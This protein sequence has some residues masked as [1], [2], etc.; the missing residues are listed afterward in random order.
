LKSCFRTDRYQKLKY[1]MSEPATPLNA[2]EAK[3]H[4]TELVLEH[5][6][7]PQPFRTKYLRELEEDL[8]PIFIQMARDSWTL[9][10]LLV[11]RGTRAG[12]DS[13][14]AYATQRG[15]EDVGRLNYALEEI[16][17]N[18]FLRDLAVSPYVAMLGSLPVDPYEERLLKATAHPNPGAVVPEL[19]QR[20]AADPSLIASPSDKLGQA[21]QTLLRIHEE[22]HS[23]EK[24]ADKPSAPPKSAAPSPD[25]M[26]PKRRRLFTGLGSLFSGLVL[27]AGNGIFIPS[28]ITTGGLAAVPLIASVAGG[29]AAVGKGAGDLNR[30]GE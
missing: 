25:T 3:K 19:L 30:E 28:V 22:I 17:V 8:L 21:A 27:L 26:R 12:D 14:L 7:I 13:F 11:V 16:G 4:L 6:G 5:F 20:V 23:K 18:D 1:F 2:E 15:P 24:A 9:R 10:Q 29:I